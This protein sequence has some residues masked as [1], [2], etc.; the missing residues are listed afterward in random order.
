MVQIL[1]KNK[2]SFFNQTLINKKREEAEK[3]FNLKK[4]EMLALKTAQASQEDGPSKD[5]RG[6]V[7][8]AIEKKEEQK[9]LSTLSLKEMVENKD[10]AKV[11]P[12]ERVTIEG[13]F[14]QPEVVTKHMLWVDA[15]NIYKA[16][17]ED[18]K[19]GRTFDEVLNN[20][21]SD[22]NRIITALYKSKYFLEHYG[23]LQVQ[24][25]NKIISKKAAVSIEE[26]IQPDY[27]VCLEDGQP[28]KLLKRYIKRFGLTPAEYKAKWN[29]PEDYPM[30]PPSL[31][32]AKSKVAKQSELFKESPFYKR[33]KM[34]KQ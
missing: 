1:H 17:Q 4:K 21:D 16:Y 18:L 32:A 9:P 11:S 3:L 5:I 33:G 28:T 25:N 19:Y 26:S 23:E 14:Y 6:D 31:S 12:E 15:M 7:P 13:K 27:L 22:L 24:E 2:P 34:R 20:L 29:L 10:T 30:C 8:Q